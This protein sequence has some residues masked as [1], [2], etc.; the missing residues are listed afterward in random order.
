MKNRSL[1]FTSSAALAAG[2]LLAVLSGC[3]KQERADAGAKAKEVYVDSK[4][5]LS[6]GWDKVK[7]ATF[8]KRGDVEAAGKALAAEMDAQA[9]KM[10]ANYSDAKA[11]ASRKA[12]MEEFKNAEADYKQKLSALGTASADTWE[13][14]KNNTIAAWDKL[15]AA[16]RKALVE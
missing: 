10:R 13:S 12:A 16:Y 6:R 14:A 3:N 9:S 7:T 8:D 5:A 4:A 15:E 1:R 2:V 11:S